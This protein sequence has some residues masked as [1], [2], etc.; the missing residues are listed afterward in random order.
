MFAL[1]GLAL[2]L[3]VGG[4]AIGIAYGIPIDDIGGTVADTLGGVLVQL[5]AVWVFSGLAAALFGV[6]P[7]FTLLAWG[8]LVVVFLLGQLGPI[9]ELDQW[10]LDISPFT[11]YPRSRWR[12]HGRTSAVV[13]GGGRRVHA[14]RVCRVR[15]RDVGCKIR[16]LASLNAV[17][18]PQVTPKLVGSRALRPGGT[19]RPVLLLPDRGAFA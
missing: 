3:L 11:M 14:P 10:V 1:L 18:R 15:R 9:L 13:R 19:A 17:R 16:V 2:L 8:S 4:L 5:P 12:V 7:R 6:A